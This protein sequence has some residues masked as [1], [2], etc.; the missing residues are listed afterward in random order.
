M[1][2]L[3]SLVYTLVNVAHM[4][5]HPRAKALA[6]SV[7]ESGSGREFARAVTAAP[8]RG[9]LAR[10]NGTRKWRENP[11]AV[12]SSAVSAPS[13]PARPGHNFQLPLP[14]R[15]S[16]AGAGAALAVAVAVQW[17]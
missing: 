6:R 4:W 10:G 14:S 16:G 17:D 13:V 8:W 15:H 3:L 9:M 12:A 2:Y 1:Y 11:G 5:V 7:S